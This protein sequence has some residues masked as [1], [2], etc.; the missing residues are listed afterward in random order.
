[1]GP[2]LYVGMTG[3]D[4]KERLINHKQGVKASSLVQRYGLRLLPKL[5][6]H[7]NPMPYEAAVQMEV[8]LAE[9]LRSQ[10]FAVGGGH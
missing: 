3:L 10:G 4:P 8:D 7:L 2:C 5:F 6:E 9:D 1:M